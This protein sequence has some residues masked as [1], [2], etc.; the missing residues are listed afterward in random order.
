MPC[1]STACAAPCTGER[2][3]AGN[4]QEL[5][6]VEH[7]LAAVEEILQRLNEDG[8]AQRPAQGDEDAWSDDEGGGPP[9]AA[10]AASA[11][12]PASAS[13]AGA[14]AAGD[15]GREAG[16]AAAAEAQDR[17]QLQRVVM[18]TRLAGLQSRQREL[19]VKLLTPA[20][21]LHCSELRRGTTLVNGLVMGRSAFP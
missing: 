14:P 19:E 8:D 20:A 13:A 11:E 12:Q 9:A 4:R 3:A 2:Q 15:S 17:G 6:A 16:R 5:L 18:S 21:R 7:E 1:A 10:A